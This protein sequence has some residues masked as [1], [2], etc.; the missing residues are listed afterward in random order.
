MH[1]ALNRHSASIVDKITGNGL[2]ILAEVMHHD[3]N[4]VQ[5]MVKQFTDVKPLDYSINVTDECLRSFLGNVQ[6]SNVK[7]PMKELEDCTKYFQ[8]I[9]S[10]VVIGVHVR[11]D[12][13]NKLELN[14][15]K[16]LF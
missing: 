4:T 12:E 2:P 14:K 5:I 11:A 6:V 10:Y 1:V 15:H 3:K 7:T 8:G 13:K 9:Y 16:Q